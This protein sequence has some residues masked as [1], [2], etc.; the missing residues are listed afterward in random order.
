M[1]G[2]PAAEFRARSCH[3]IVYLKLILLLTL[4]SIK[5]EIYSIYLYC[6]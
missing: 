6:V 2:L 3:L 4:L 5:V 1:D